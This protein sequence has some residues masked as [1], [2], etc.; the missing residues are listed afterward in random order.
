MYPLRSPKD[1]QGFLDHPLER[2][3]ERYKHHELHFF[4]LID[5]H[6]LVPSLVRSWQ[7]L[8]LPCGVPSGFAAAAHIKS[9]T[10]RNRPKGNEEG[11]KC[12]HR[13]LAGP[14]ALRTLRWKSR[15]RGRGEPSAGAGIPVRLCLANYARTL[16]FCFCGAAHS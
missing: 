16:V 4:R 10:A 12:L 2:L 1:L 13:F 9:Q 6:I 5:L 11:S 15:S 3:S 14:V 7:S 8:P